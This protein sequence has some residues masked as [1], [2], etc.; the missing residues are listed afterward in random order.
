MPCVDDGATMRGK[1]WERWVS[2]LCAVVFLVWAW[3]SSPINLRDRLFP[4]HLVEVYPDLLYRSGQI[5][6]RLIE[7][8][9]RDLDIDLIVDLTGEHGSEEQ[10]VEREV[11]KRLGI[12]YR[13]FQL[14]GSGT[15][16]VDQYVGAIEAID[17]AVSEQRAVLVHCR[18]GD[19]R[20]GGVVAAYQLLV[21]GESTERA[22]EEIQR[23]ARRPVHEA[24][25]WSYLEEQLPEMARRLS[26]RGVE[27]RG[28]WDPLSPVGSF[29]GTGER[30]DG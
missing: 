27:L 21:R 15:G 18:A 23:F 14:G 10:R 16:D 9:L 8:T 13:A 7:G 28:S 20:T 25:L 3:N 2:S 12:E 30:G 22:V 19:R 6:A 29:V 11:A 26:L 24:R 4:K 1:H 5:D 17:R